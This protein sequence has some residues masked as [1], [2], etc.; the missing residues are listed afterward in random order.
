M[1]FL[2]ALPPK[3]VG[4]QALRYI[5]TEVNFGVG[6]AA[7]ILNAEFYVLQDKLQ[8]RSLQSDAID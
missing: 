2:W 3:K 1:F 7:S 6:D 4:G 8:F 5:P